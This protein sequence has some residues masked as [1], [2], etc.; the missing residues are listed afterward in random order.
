GR[1]LGRRP[2]WH[3]WYS[4]H[5]LPLNVVARECSECAQAG[6]EN[7]SGHHSIPVMRFVGPPEQQEYSKIKPKSTS[8]KIAHKQMG[9]HFE[10]RH[11]GE[12][13]GTPK[14]QQYASE[15]YRSEL[16]HFPYPF[17]RKH[18]VRIMCRSAV[19]RQPLVLHA[20][21]ALESERCKSIL[22]A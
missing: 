10:P 17:Y 3:R 1:R 14:E 13:E 9:E 20:S 8:D 16:P 11:Y 6:E 22:L 21:W 4:Q 2:C 7:Y 12:H 19:Q 5:R 18:S 15:N